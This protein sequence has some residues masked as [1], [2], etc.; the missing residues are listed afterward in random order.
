MVLP[1]PLLSRP[2]W[3][4]SSGIC[5][6][7]C[8]RRPRMSI[9]GGRRSAERR[10]HRHKGETSAA[11]R[12]SVRRPPDPSLIS[13]GKPKPG[14]LRALRRRDAG[15][16]SV[17]R[18]WGGRPAKGRH[19]PRPPPDVTGGWNVTSDRRRTRWSVRLVTSEPPSDAMGDGFTTLKDHL[20]SSRWAAVPSDD[21]HS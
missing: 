5:C 15:A 21:H 12:Y 10:C 18:R 7:V 19:R 4:K 6:G 3:T 1:G 13:G 11:P 2:S 9:G 8:H 20:W 16:P 17:R 14:R